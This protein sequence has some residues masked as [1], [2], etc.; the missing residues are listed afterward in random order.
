MSLLF[1]KKE[2]PGSN[3]IL[4]LSPYDVAVVKSVHKDQ[5]LFVVNHLTYKTAMHIL[6]QRYRKAKLSDDGPIYEVDNVQFQNNIEY[7]DY[8]L[9]IYVD[10]L[11]DK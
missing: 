9:A 4:K 2:Y 7:D 5:D 3:N 1:N 6:G 10:A 11:E 8:A